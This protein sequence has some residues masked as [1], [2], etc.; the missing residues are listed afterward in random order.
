MAA[1]SA[2]NVAPKPLGYVASN[3]AQSWGKLRGSTRP[4]LAI[5]SPRTRLERG[6]TCPT[7]RGDLTIFVV[8][9]AGLAGVGVEHAQAFPALE[10][11]HP[12]TRGNVRRRG[13]PP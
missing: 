11:R 3:H 9:S 1:A 2:G 13:A 8:L 5:R 6:H 4:R 12:N 10:H 7:E